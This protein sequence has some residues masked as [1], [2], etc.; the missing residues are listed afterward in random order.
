VASL[1]LANMLAEL[2]EGIDADWSEI[3]PALK[4]DRRIGPFAYL[5]PGLGIAGGNLERDLATVRRLAE[6]QGSNAGLVK[7]W[8]DDSR[9]RRDWAVR[10]IRT[11]LL[12][13]NPEAALATRKIPIP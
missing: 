11:A 12:D 10:T 1:S 3:V 9:Y 13:T 6:A 2:C 4:L 8:S 7:A 5:A